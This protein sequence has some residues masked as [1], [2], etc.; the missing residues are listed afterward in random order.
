MERL[1]KVIAAIIGVAMLALFTIVGPIVDRV[2]NRVDGEPLGAVGGEAHAIHARHTVVDLHSDALLWPRKLLKQINHGHVDLPRLQLGNVA[3]EVFSVVTKVPRGL[4]YERND[5]T[6]DMIEYLAVASRWPVVAWAS[7][8]ARAEQQAGKLRTA[9]RRSNGQLV[10]LRTAADLD[11]VLL[12]RSR[13]EQVTGAMLAIEGA[14][15][16]EGKLSNVAALDSAGFRMIG[17]V[18]FFDNAFAGS[19][20]G[21]MKGGLTPL[22][23][24]LV[25]ELERRRIIID[26][27]HASAKTIDDVLAVAT[28]P[29]VVSHTG[30]KAT[31][32]SPRNLSDDQ[33]R[34]IAATGGVIGIGYWEEAVCD[35]APASIARAISHVVAVG[36]IDHV[37]LGSDFDGATVTRFDASQLAQ[38]TQALVD[39]GFEEGEIAKILGG[40]AVRVLRAGLPTGVAGG[41]P[42]S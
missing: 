2:L 19:S 3:V 13:G 21:M 5:S 20:A 24:S 12:R 26:L 1:L 39:A 27:A 38:V 33:I 40:N 7:R 36:G 16:L 9:V 25:V 35:L 42:T 10:L 37:A 32:D 6:T 34:R 4:N 29:V 30:V 18:H 8:M 31:C 14:H 17:L 28:R 22:G 41:S 23:D 11:A 15:A